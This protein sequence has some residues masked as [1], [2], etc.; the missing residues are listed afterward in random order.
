VGGVPEVIQADNGILINSG[1]E[2][3]LL[4]AMKKM[5]LNH[6]SYDK[7]KISRRATAEFSYET[8]GK[9]IVEVYNSVLDRK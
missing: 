6:V 1:D 7:D 8:V 4:E 5:M 9:E 2:K 3:E